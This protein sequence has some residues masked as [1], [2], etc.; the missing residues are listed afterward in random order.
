M[1]LTDHHTKRIIII[2]GLLIAISPFSIDTYLPAFPAIAA[3]LKTDIAHVGYSLTSYYAGLC[4][5]QL[6]YG[7]LIDRFGRKKP[8]I[9]GL[10]LYFVATVLCALSTSI[11]MLVAVRLLMALGGC[12]GMVAARAMVRDL[13]SPEDT[14]KVLSQLV[15]IMGVAPIIAPSIGG[16][17]N[18]TFG[19]RWVF[20]AIAI[21]ALLL[22]AAVNWLLPETKQADSTVSLAPKH[23]LAEYG[24]VFKNRTFL[25]YTLAGGISYAGLYAYIAG[26]PFVF[27]EVF[28][29]SPAAYGLAF[30]ANACGLII[31]SQLNRV[32]LKKH[33]SAHVCKWA[34]ILLFITGLS[35]LT[36][37][38][39]GTADARFTLCC[40]FLFL[41][42]L[43]FINPNTTALA[44]RPFTVAAGRA[45]A[46]LGSIQMIAGVLA[47][48][49]VSL[50]HNGTPVIMAAVMFVCTAAPAAILVMPS[51][52]AITRRRMNQE[53]P[54]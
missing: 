34:T 53:C 48:W 51:L 32:L 2:L 39:N 16:F 25:V 5:G 49:M 50:L 52:S 20:G 8:L 1:K 23:L 28:G 29:F 21:I 9:I 12:V 35:L 3:A 27:M 43:G 24:A 19:W 31:G 7:V 40:T 15:L 6:I 30:S 17:I 22:T 4:T 18:S 46:L 42:C 37:T 11:G 47:S 45:S 36:A 10:L 38:I 13:F 41:F 33:E 54:R 14:A 44:L 26:S